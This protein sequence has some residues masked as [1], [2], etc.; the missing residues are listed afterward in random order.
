MI[1]LDSPYG[2]LNTLILNL[3]IFLSGG[4]FLLGELPPLTEKLNATVA[5]KCYCYAT[6]SGMPQTVA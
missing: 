3:A 6:D 1:L 2:S 4:T 5:I